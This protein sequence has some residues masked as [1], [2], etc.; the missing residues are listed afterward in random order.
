MTDLE[1]IT[2]LAEIKSNR[3]LRESWASFLGRY[4]WSWWATFTFEE[5]FKSF[6]ARRRLENFFTTIERKVH[7]RVPAFV[8]EEWTLG[9]PDVPHYHALIGDVSDLSRAYWWSQ[10]FHRRGNGRAQILPYE[11]AKGARYY[12]TKYVI[13]DE[14]IRGA[15][16]VRRMPS[17]EKAQD[18]VVP[19]TQELPV[20]AEEVVEKVVAMFGGK[21]YL[22]K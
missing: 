16:F 13:K 8:A 12:L 2:S 19:G 14:Y 5:E 1:Y 3:R 21:R 11:V 15:W 7:R 4:P 10:W 20:E 17:P 9:R 6:T 18:W 22:L